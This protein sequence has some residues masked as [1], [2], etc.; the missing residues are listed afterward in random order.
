MCNRWLWSGSEILIRVKHSWS[1]I[2]CTCRH[3]ALHVTGDPQ[4]DDRLGVLWVVQDGRYV[5]SW[6][7]ILGDVSTMRHHWSHHKECSF[8]RI[9]YS[10]LQCGAVWSKLPGHARRCVHERRSS[11]DTTTLGVGRAAVNDGEHDARMLACKS[12]SSS[13]RAESE[14]DFK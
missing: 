1:V 8:W 9:R 13:H 11:L 2:E 6:S 3:K 7:A 10:I 12:V 5:C 4:R 14:K